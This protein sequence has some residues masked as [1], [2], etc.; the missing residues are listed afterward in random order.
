[1]FNVVQHMVNAL[2]YSTFTYSQKPFQTR[3][4][5]KKLLGVGEGVSF[6]QKGT[7][8]DHLKQIA[9]IG[10]DVLYLPYC[11]KCHIPCK[12]IA[13]FFMLRAHGREI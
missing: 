1:M 2:Q 9:T 4:F 11:Q 7:I 12:L 3:A 8:W 10:W 5:G 13:V 6:S